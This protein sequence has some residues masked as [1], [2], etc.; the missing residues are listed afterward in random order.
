MLLTIILGGSFL[1]S[2]I[3]SSSTSFV[4]TCSIWTSSS[5][6]ALRFLLKTPL[7]KVLKKSI[8]DTT[9]MFDFCLKILLAA[10]SFSSVFCYSP[11]LITLLLIFLTSSLF[12]IRLDVRF[13]FFL[14]FNIYRFFSAAD[15]AAGGIMNS[16][17]LYNKYIA[18]NVEITW[19]NYTFDI[20]HQPVF[21]HLIS[22]KW[23]RWG[24]FDCYWCTSPAVQSIFQ[25]VESSSLYLLRQKRSLPHMSIKKN[26]E[27][28]YS[29][30][31]LHNWFLTHYYLFRRRNDPNEQWPVTFWIQCMRSKLKKLNMLL[32]LL[33]LSISL[34]SEI[35]CNC[36]FWQ[37]QKKG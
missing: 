5:F 7:A 17:S 27:W 15:T 29:T 9:I 6:F 4:Y 26:K 34:E 18:F 2:Y 12:M 28:Q 3:F 37:S 32:L 33:E 23:C 13:F 21:I 22:F 14:Q 8:I 35:W 36:S 24:I 25:H 31:H 16:S 30:N 19:M 1:V 11:D 10:P 20:N